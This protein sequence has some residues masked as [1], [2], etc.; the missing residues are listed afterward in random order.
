MKL[1]KQ[2]KLLTF[3]LIVS[4]FFLSTQISF[5]VEG[6]KINLKDWQGPYVGLGYADSK[7]V[8]DHTETFRGVPNGYTGDTSIKKKN[9]K[10]IYWAQLGS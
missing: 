8:D 5:A 10:Y 9:S 6:K 3:Q 7:L 2:S 1:I 4:L